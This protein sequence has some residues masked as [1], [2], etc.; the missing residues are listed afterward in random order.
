MGN[1]KGKALTGNNLSFSFFQDP[2]DVE[3]VKEKIWKA[4]KQG[5]KFKKQIE[6]LVWCFKGP[7]VLPQTHHDSFLIKKYK[8]LIPT[9][10]L[11]R[12]IEFINKGKDLEDLIATDIE[13]LIYL[14]EL[15]LM[16]PI[17][18]EG[19]MIYQYIFKKIIKKYPHLHGLEKPTQ[20]DFETLFENIG[21]KEDPDELNDYYKNELYQLQRW[22]FEKSFKEFKKQIND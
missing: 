10:R 15:S 21:I 1:P 17:T 5:N 20:E 16:H 4:Q 11:L 3:K 6:Y 13:T 12:I 22:L 14:C 8:D 18:K 19:Y 7:I 9:E 2:I